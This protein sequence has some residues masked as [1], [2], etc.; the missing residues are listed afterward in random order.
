MSYQPISLWRLTLVQ[1]LRS[2]PCYNV[3]HYATTQGEPLSPTAT[4]ENIGAGF[5]WRMLLPLRALASQQVVF[6]SVR[7]EELQ[8]GAG[9]AEVSAGNVPGDVAGELINLFTAY[10]FIS[11]RKTRNVRSGH[12]RFAGV[13]EPVNIDGNIS[14]SFNIPLTNAATAL[15]ST[16][17]DPAAAYVVNLFPVIASFYDGPILRPVPIVE[18]ATYTYQGVTSQVSRKRRG[19]GV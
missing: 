15:S 1:V 14:G 19:V 2:Q 6:V 5:L 13:T 3:F 8:G 9:L 7:I 11:R 17:Q 10:S 16:I 4:P 12:K 18:P